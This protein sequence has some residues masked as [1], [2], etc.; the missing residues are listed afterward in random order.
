M[1]SKAC[2][3]F[4]SRGVMN[5]STGRENT[6]AMCTAS[7]QWRELILRLVEVLEHIQNHKI[8][9]LTIDVLKDN[10]DNFWLI[11][12]YDLIKEDKEDKYMVMQ[13]TKSK[14]RKRVNKCACGLY[15]KLENDL[16][17]L[18]DDYD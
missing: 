10:F 3:K 11:D 6:L 8:V 7:S 5:S 2:Y 9:T 15:C 13:K 14:L 1:K 4:N 18:F 12:A 17:E 16:A